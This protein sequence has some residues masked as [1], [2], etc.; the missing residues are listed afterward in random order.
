[1]TAPTTGPNPD[2]S[3]D[4]LVLLDTDDDRDLRATV[5]GYLAARC[6]STAVAAVYDGDRSVVAPL[7]RGLATELGLAGLLVPESYAGAGATP[8]DAAVVLEELGRSV[9][10]VPF[11]TSSV[12]AATTLAHASTDAGRSLLAD[13][14]EGGRTVALVVPLTTAFDADVPVVQGHGQVHVRSVA[15][16][17]DADTLL[18]PVAAGDGIELH[19]VPAGDARIEPVVSLDM[20]RELADVTVDPTAGTVAVEGDAAAGVRAGLL[21]GTTLLASEQVGIAQWCL[22]ATVGH[23]QERRQFGRV[24]GGF[25]ALKHRLADLYTAVEGASATARFAAAALAADPHGEEARIAAHTAAAWCSDVAVLAAE[26]AVQLHGGIGMTWEHPAHLYL[27][28]AKADQLALGLPGHHRARLGE[29]V[30][31]TV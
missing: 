22:Q 15:G 3:P 13:L 28:R 18:V 5:A 6:P 14:A 11:L 30:G 31:L 17:L 9:A 27:K 4:E 19:A 25:Q 2:P 10:P 26:E 24:V 23:L 29:L 7:W 16:A 12:I 8:R 1:M 21:A 20:S